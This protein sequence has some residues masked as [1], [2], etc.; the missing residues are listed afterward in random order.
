[1]RLPNY[2]LALLFASIG[3]AFAECAPDKLIRME[4]QNVSPGIP[5]DSFA[6]QPKVQYRL[7]NG[8]SRTEEQPD[9]GDG[10]QL[11][12][13]TD[14]PRVWQIDLVKKTGE[15]MVDDD[16]PSKLTMSVFAEDSLPPEILAVEY[17]CE[18]QFM[19]DP[20]TTH[21]RRETS[22]GVAIKHSIFAG[23]WKFTLVTREGSDVPMLALLSQNDKVVASVRYL[24]YRTVE[25][26]PAGLFEPPPGMTIHAAQ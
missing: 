20:R 24:S 22:N 23:A 4:T 8:R 26:V 3:P 10:V 21:E 25:T 2:S 6:R 17:G 5:A 18:R 1:M 19:Q 15:M 11:L 9:P 16:V 12:F 14:T 7:G 13:I